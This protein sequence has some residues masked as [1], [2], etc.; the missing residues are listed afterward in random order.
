MVHVQELVD[1]IARLLDASV[2]LEDRSFQLVAYG[3]QSG[4]IDA[5]REEVI[6]RRRATDAT[7]AHFEAYG[8]A[9][10]EGPVRIPAIAGVLGRVCVPL[11]HKGVTYGYLWLLDS[12]DL[13]DDRLKTV[14][15]LVARAAA[16]LARESQ[17]RQVP[18]DDLFSANPDTRAASAADLEG[19]LVAMATRAAPGQ[20]AA[21][22]TLP[23][24][25]RIDLTLTHPAFLVPAA[26]ARDVARRVQDMYGTA[27]GVGAPR[28]DAADA[29]ESWREALGALRVAEARKIPIAYWDDLGVYRYLVKLPHSELA[30]LAAEAAPLGELAAT[31]ECYL[32][33]GGH[34]QETAAALGV[35][36]QTLYYR[37][38]RA[39]EATGLNLADGRDRLVLH[40]ALKASHL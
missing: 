6:L 9:T 1:E 16:T 13:T 36:R 5:V 7:R 22:W 35:H 23:H 11:R 26:Q 37:L 2:T 33:H 15:P 28:Q 12:G 24:D 21:L 31:V 29:W 38:G 27:T 32:D 14:E 20:V 25:V 34:V 30:A 4:D 17:T 39:A 8:I 10:A 3:A 40:L 19:P 18:L